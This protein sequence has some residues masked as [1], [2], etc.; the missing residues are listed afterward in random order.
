V[1]V[2]GVVVRDQMQHFVLGC[3]AVDLLEELQ[4]LEVGVALL[5]LAD[6]LRRSRFFGQSAKL[7]LTG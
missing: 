4:P 2:S 3:F 6:D 7:R 5:A 1:F